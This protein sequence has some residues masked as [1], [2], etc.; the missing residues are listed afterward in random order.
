MAK[1]GVNTVGLTE[2]N[3]SKSKAT[4]ANKKIKGKT[5]TYEAFGENEDD[6]TRTTRTENYDPTRTSRNTVVFTDP[7]IK[8]GKDL[9]K[10]IKDE[11]R[12]YREPY[13]WTNAEGEEC[14]TERKPRKDKV[15]GRMFTLTPGREIAEALQGDFEQQDTFV[16]CELEALQVLQPELFGDNLLAYATHR[17]EGRD[18]IDFHT[19][20]LCSTKHG[21]KWS[22]TCF[23]PYKLMTRTIYPN[24]PEV[25]REVLR[26]HSADFGGRDLSPLIEEYDRIDNERYKNDPEYRSERRKKRAGYGLS[27]NQYAAKK[28]HERAVAALEARISEL[29]ADRDAKGLELDAKGLELD[30]MTTRAKAAEKKAVE[31]RKGR[32]REAAARKAEHS[33]KQEAERRAVE[34][35]QRAAEQAARADHFQKKVKDWE[36]WHKQAKRRGFDRQFFAGI[37][38]DL[39]VD[40]G[41]RR[42]NAALD[43]MRRFSYKRR[44]TKEAQASTAQLEAELPPDTMAKTWRT[45]EKWQAKVMAEVGPELD[46]SGLSD[47]TIDIF[48]EISDARK[49]CDRAGKKAWN[50]AEGPGGVKNHVY[51]TAIR[52]ESDRREGLPVEEK[53]APEQVKQAP[54]QSPKPRARDDGD[55]LGLDS[56]NILVPDEEQEKREALMGELL[57]MSNACTPEGR[58]GEALEISLGR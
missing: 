54:E 32:E 19:H 33:A 50:R 58:Q 22:S 17:D 20:I 38:A 14:V 53:K 37:A 7:H 56:E 36:A 1:I 45:L 30:R 10:S 2:G 41:L 8:C 23:D 13:R 52:R 55:Y 51:L 11:L 48:L 27:A 28:E 3:V 40:R 6:L 16:A 5:A 18:E 46:A 9:Y 43:V 24:Y 12:D 47:G 25:L 21:E 42:L 49:R 44:S 39:A 4:G 31:E 15:W 29:E 26:A 34:N 57:D 35:E